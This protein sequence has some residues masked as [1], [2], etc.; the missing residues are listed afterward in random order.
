[1]KILGGWGQPPPAERAAVISQHLL[2]LSGSTGNRSP[3]L[4]SMDRIKAKTMGFT[5]RIPGSVRSPAPLL[6]TPGFPFQG[7]AL[8]PGG[9]AAWDAGTSAPAWPACFPWERMRPT[10]SPKRWRI[11]S[12]NG[13]SLSTTLLP[14]RSVY[15]SALRA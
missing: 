12:S 4:L 15:A 14:E 9:M 13:V 6:A 10:G 1:M 2:W 11:T 3:F 5:V 8:H 7:Q